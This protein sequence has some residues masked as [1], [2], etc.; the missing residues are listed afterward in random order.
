MTN[1]CRI[2]FL[3]LFLLCGILNVSSENINA[4]SSSKSNVEAAIASASD[5][6]VVFVPAGNSTWSSRVTV[7]KA[8]TIFGAGIGNTIITDF[9]FDV[10]D[11][12][13]NWRIS[14]FEFI[15][16]SVAGTN[17][18]INVGAFHSSVGVRN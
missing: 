2:S 5:G 18:I 16:S 12:T 6:D 13:N 3:S 14:H 11:G 17:P 7:N 15:N 1:L 9:G 4:A 8:I 10:A